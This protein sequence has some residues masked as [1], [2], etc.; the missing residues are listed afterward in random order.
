QEEALAAQRAALAPAEPN[1]FE[2]AIDR[3][4]GRLG[5][6]VEQGVRQAFSGREAARLSAA[7]EELAALRALRDGGEAPQGFYQR[8][9]MDLIPYERDAEARDERIAELE[10]WIG[11]RARAFSG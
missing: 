10:G 7:E 4:G 6:R 2:R 5:R 1:T 3:A 9:P 8:R 11:E